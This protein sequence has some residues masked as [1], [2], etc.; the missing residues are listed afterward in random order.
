MTDV[1]NT[2]YHDTYIREVRVTYHSTDTRFFSITQPEEAAAFIRTVL[3]DNSREHF[4]ALYLNAVNRVTA[5]SLVATGTA[6]SCVVHAREVLQ[7]AI[8]CGAV[9]LIVAH[10]HPSGNTSPSDADLKLTK[11]IKEAC[12]IIGIPLL[13]HL[14]IND[15][16][17][18]SIIDW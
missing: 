6:N 10:N 5:Y 3:V 18:T 12:E 13:A 8:L 11:Q 7:R 17:R 2:L 9:S 14:I 1:E 16:S 4:V 15:F